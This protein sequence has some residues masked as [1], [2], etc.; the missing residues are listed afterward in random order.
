MALRGFFRDLTVGFAIGM[1]TLAAFFAVVV[2]L[3]L[4]F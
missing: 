3:F 1:A 4:I 2:V